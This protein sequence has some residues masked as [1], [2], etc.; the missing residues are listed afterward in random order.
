M[1]HNLCRMSSILVFGIGF[2]AQLLFFG[3]TILQWFKSEHAGEVISPVIF[4]Q[5]SLIAS[6]LMLTYGIMRNDFAIITGQFLVYFIYIRNLQLKNAWKPIHPVLRF[7]ALILPLIIVIC[8]FTNNTYN[9]SKIIRNEEISNLLMLWGLAGQI[10][11]TSR[12]IYQ[13]TFSEK[14]RE[15]VLPLGFWIL[16]SVGAAMIFIYSIFRLDP[17]LFMAHVLGI[18]IY[19]R[20]ILLF[21][22]KRGLFSRTNLSFLN[23]FTQK[24]S[25]KLH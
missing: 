8:L 5:L 23:R 11:F 20:N 24:L 16:S 12:F 3:R 7:I 9:F 15:S 17:V 1:S 25:D 22:G 6:V 19:I 14:K 2:S 13:W 4:W 21:Y 10:V 18:F